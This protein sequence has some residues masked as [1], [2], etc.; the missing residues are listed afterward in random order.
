[1]WQKYPQPLEDILRRLI[2]DDDTCV[3]AVNDRN[4]GFCRHTSINCE[5]FIENCVKD[6]EENFKRI[7]LHFFH[8]F[9]IF[10]LLSVMTLPLNE[11]KKKREKVSTPTKLYFRLQ[12]FFFS[13]RD[14]F[15]TS[16]TY[17]NANCEKNKRRRGE[18]EREKCMKVQVSCM[19]R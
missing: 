2:Y 13:Y 11:G 9:L 14:T 6:A 15:L 18:R 16:Q 17:I 12:L 3:C 10:S 8:Q 5:N 7:F 1:M 4:I 19:W